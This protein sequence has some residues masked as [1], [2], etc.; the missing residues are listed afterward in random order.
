MIPAVLSADPLWAVV[1]V[2]LFNMLAVLLT[3]FFTRRYY[4]WLAGI[5][6]ALLYTAA[7]KPLNYSRLIWQPNLLA[8][9][10]ML[11]MFA[12]F[13]GGV[14]RRRG[15]FFPAVFLFGVIYQLHEISVVLVIPLLVTLVLAPGTLR[16]RDLVLAL[17]SI[18]VIFSP[19]ILWSTLQGLQ[20]CILFSRWQNYT[21][22]LTAM[23]VTSTKSFF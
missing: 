9:F 23:L 3:Y 7:A 15:W 21:Y 13:W 20:M 22:I 6:A 1:T 10:I 16:W 5:I 4:G 19:Y 11:F 12:L 8:P 14:E 18:L 2:G 17:I